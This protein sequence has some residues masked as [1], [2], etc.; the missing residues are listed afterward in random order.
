MTIGKFIFTITGKLPSKNE[1]KQLNNVT[2]V[3]EL[4][5]V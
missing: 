3:E 1:R 5:D 4:V 2:N